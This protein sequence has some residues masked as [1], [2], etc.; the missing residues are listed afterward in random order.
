MWLERDWKERVIHKMDCRA[1]GKTN[2]DALSTPM[3]ARLNG[4]SET[5]CVCSAPEILVCQTSAEV[6]GNARSMQGS[7]LR[8]Q[9]IYAQ[10]VDLT[11]LIGPVNL[12]PGYRADLTLDCNEGMR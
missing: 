6:R 3:Y 9:S 2:V 1:C 8:G 12:V 11:L 7:E 4:L 5:I 10:P